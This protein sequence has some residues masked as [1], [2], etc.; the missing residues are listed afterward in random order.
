[1]P[2][3][4]VFVEPSLSSPTRFCALALKARLCLIVSMVF[5]AA[6]CSSDP[7]MEALEKCVRLLEGILE[8]KVLHDAV[9]NAD[10]QMQATT[11]A[12]GALSGGVTANFPRPPDS[13]AIV[14]TPQEVQPWSVVLIGDDAAREVRIQGYGE[15]ASK[16]EIVK[17]V[18]FPSR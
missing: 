18:K 5:L 9:K 13:I 4:Q 11:A 3:P 15:S 8:S 12:R 2:A 7:R 17:K 1:M 10:P 14:D 16:P 6:G